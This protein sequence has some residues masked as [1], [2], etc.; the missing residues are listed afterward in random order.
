M[1]FLKT[2]FKR[3]MGIFPPQL[4]LKKEK[5]NCK[6][7]KDFGFRCRS[8]LVKSKAKDKKTFQINLN[9]KRQTVF[10]LS[11]DVCLHVCPCTVARQAEEDTAST[12]AGN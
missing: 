2:G 6:I 1:H 4:K 10:K 9:L 12:A 3:G 5:G 8:L 11:L 7:L